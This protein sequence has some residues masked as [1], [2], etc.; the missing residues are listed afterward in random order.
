M[1]KE[2]EYKRENVCLGKKNQQIILLKSESSS[3]QITLF[4]L[5]WLSVSTLTLLH[6]S[7]SYWH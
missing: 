4:P 5:S 6:N 3:V 2:A 1:R 7:N